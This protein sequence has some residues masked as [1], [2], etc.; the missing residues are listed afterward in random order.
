MSETMARRLLTDPEVVRAVAHQQFEP[1]LGR[2]AGMV[3]PMLLEGG[4]LFVMAEGNAR[5]PDGTPVRL[6]FTAEIVE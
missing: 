6:R 4:P 3:H 5:L 1:V 2:L